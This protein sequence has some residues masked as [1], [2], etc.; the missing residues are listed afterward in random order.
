M[1]LFSDDPAI[2]LNYAIFLYNMG[3]KKHAA[4]QFSIYEKKMEVFRQTKANDVDREVDHENTFL[5]V[6]LFVCSFVC[7]FVCLFVR[8]SVCL[9]LVC[10]FVRLS[11]CLFVYFFACS[12]I[13]CTILNV[14]LVAFY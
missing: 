3:D 7:L 1:L 11:V 13:S 6:C 14:L 9:F 8:L 5:F 10:L 12:F 4:K 2:S